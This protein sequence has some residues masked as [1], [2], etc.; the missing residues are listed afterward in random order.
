MDD[1][2]IPKSNSRDPILEKDRV[3]NSIPGFK[4]WI[5]QTSLFNTI[6]MHVGSGIRIDLI[7]NNAS[8]ILNK[9]GKVEKAEDLP[10]E[11]IVEFFINSPYYCNKTNFDNIKLIMNL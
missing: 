4:E 8:Y 11:M 2:L 1:K 10:I 7:P 6:K 9:G 3:F 5:E